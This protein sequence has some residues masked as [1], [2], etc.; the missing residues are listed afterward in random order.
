MGYKILSCSIDWHW[1]HNILTLFFDEHLVFEGL[2]LYNSAV[3]NGK[4]DIRMV[5]VFFVIFFLRCLY[6]RLADYTKPRFLSPLTL[7][8]S[9]VS[10]QDLPFCQNLSGF[11]VIIKYHHQKKNIFS[12]QLFFLCNALNIFLLTFLILWAKTKNSHICSSNHWFPGASRLGKCWD[13][14]WPGLNVDNTFLSSIAH[15]F[16]VFKGD[17]RQK[18]VQQNLTLP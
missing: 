2:H 5:I 4:K 6:F 17:G 8:V 3:K 13:Q 7:A 1:P 10:Y 14:C 9:I 18:H 15:M 12:S 16:I 11:L